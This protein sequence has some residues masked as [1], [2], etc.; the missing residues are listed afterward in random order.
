[1]SVKIRPVELSDRAAWNALWKAYVKFYDGKLPKDVVETLWWRLHD[2]ASSVRGVVAVNNGKVIGIAHYVLSPHTWSRNH[3]CYLE[4][5][6]V[7]NAAR[8]QG[9][10]RAMIAWLHAEARRHGWKRLYWMTD[11]N[12]KTAQHLYDRVAERTQWIR[13]DMDLTKSVSSPRK[14]GSSG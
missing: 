9:A 1:M 10:A 11:A 6:F 13:Y 12:N 5:L 8:G 4:D 2:K 7:S 3:I 14:R